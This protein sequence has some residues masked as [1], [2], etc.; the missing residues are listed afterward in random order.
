[1]AGLTAVWAREVDLVAPLND[2]A[3][4]SVKLTALYNAE[5]AQ[6]DGLDGLLDGIISNPSA[7]HFDPA[8]LTCPGST[9][10]SSVVVVTT[11][12]ATLRKPSGSSRRATRIA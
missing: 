5:V 12:D 1:M 11:D 6:C 10:T 2:S 3:T 8:I 4:L 9:N 7:C